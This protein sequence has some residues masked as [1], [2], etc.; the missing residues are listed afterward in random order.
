MAVSLAGS[1][2]YTILTSNTGGTYTAETGS[3][4]VV[5]FLC[6]T[7]H[8]GGTSRKLASA[9]YGGKDCTIIGVEEI[10][11][12]IAVGCAYLKESDVDSRTGDTF[13]PTWTTAA[14]TGGICIACFTLTDV[15]Q[16]T[17]YDAV[18]ADLRSTDGTVSPVLTSAAGSLVMALGFSNEN[19]DIALAWAQATEIVEGRIG[20]TAN[21][22]LASYAPGST[23]YSDTL[24]RTGGT[25]YSLAAI[26]VSFKAGASVD[27]IQLRW[28][29]G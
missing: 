14:P 17:V 19:T 22:S 4:R 6:A 21:Y 24:T 23:T 27:P 16:T 5:V 20:T 28:Q 2:G 15:D 3:N 1:P 18:D 9:T 10:S 29:I 25:N 12:T 26:A 11:T 13:T 7:E 8:N